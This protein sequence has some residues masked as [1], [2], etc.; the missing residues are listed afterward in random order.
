M[1]FE[2]MFCSIDLYLQI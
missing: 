1:T 2:E